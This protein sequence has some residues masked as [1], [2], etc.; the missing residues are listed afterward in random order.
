MLT[1]APRP[2]DIYHGHVGSGNVAKLGRI[3][4]ASSHLSL[5]L[6]P[7]S[8][9]SS[10]APRAVLILGISLGI[11]P[12][13]FMHYC[14]LLPICTVCHLLFWVP[15]FYHTRRAPALSPPPLRLGARRSGPYW[16]NIFIHYV[17]SSMYWIHL[18]SDLQLQHPVERAAGCHDWEMKVRNRFAITISS[19]ATWRNNAT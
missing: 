1:S 2:R 7:T 9:C 19:A 12:V 3:A 10:S 5:L 6:R 8:L 4:T 15:H 16:P 13:I 11:Y 17:P 18:T 14:P